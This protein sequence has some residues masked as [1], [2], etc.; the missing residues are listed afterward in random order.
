[1]A[2]NH[3]TVTDKAAQ[4]TLRCRPHRSR[5]APSSLSRPF[6]A[7]T[8]AFAF[9][10]SVFDYPVIDT[11]ENAYYSKAHILREP[12][13]TVHAKSQAGAL[14]SAISIVSKSNVL[15]RIRA[16]L[17]VSPVR[18]RMVAQAKCARANTIAMALQSLAGHSMTQYSMTV[19]AKTGCVGIEGASE[20][21][22]VV[23]D[24]RPSQWCDNEGSGAIRIGCGK[25]S[26]R[27]H[28]T[29]NQAVIKETEDFRH[30]LS[31][32]DCL[33][34]VGSMSRICAYATDHMGRCPRRPLRPCSSI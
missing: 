20:S 25:R 9:A 17:A 18:G 31:L 10:F 26:L 6:A 5:N 7:D 23:H 14:I 34:A 11:F 27:L 16:C 2:C 24:G 3:I 29:V 8:L 13:I 19:H 33:C 12:V 21:I 4:L 30:R 22:F 15:T 28:L 1:M 32:F